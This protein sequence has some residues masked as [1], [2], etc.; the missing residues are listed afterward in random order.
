VKIPPTQP[1]EEAEA[2]T[3]IRAAALRYP[4]RTRMALLRVLMAPQEQRAEAIGRLYAE[5]DRREAAELLIDLG[6]DRRM[7]PIVADVLK[8]SLR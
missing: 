5:P 8:E 4:P 2:E 1:P 3:E 7:A 6:E